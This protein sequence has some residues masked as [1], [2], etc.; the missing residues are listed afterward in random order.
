MGD[1]RELS[2]HGN[3]EAINLRLSCSDHR[4]DGGCCKEIE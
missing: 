2:A 3:S 1:V 4:L